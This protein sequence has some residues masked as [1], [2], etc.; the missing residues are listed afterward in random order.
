MLSVLSV[1]TYIE[2]KLTGIR[3]GFVSG[4]MNR[5]AVLIASPPYT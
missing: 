3:N 2:I 5:A 1:I 4:R